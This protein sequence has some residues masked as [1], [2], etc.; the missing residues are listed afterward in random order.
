MQEWGLS[1]EL[2]IQTKQMI[3]IAEKELSIMRQAIDKEDECILCKME[4]I[5]HMLANVQ[6]LAAT[7]YIQ[8]YLSPYTESSQFI[9]TAVQHLSAR[10]HGALIVVERNETLHPFIQTGTTLNAHLTAPLLESIFYPGNPLHDGAVLVKNNHIVSAANIL[11]LTKSTEVDPELGTRHRAAIGLSEQSDA[12]IL[13]VSE[14]TG[15][16]SFALNGTLYTISL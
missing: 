16:T 9:T 11:P 8:A 7:Y 12:L 14:E 4:D 5:H 6:T 2:K 13:V 1:E 10:K 3:E 15:R